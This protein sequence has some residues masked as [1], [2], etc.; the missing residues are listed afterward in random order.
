MTRVVKQANALRKLVGDDCPDAVFDAGLGC[1]RET[2]FFH[3]WWPDASIFGFEP[4]HNSR[5]RLEESIGE[6][7]EIFPNAI[8]NVSHETVKFHK[9]RGNRFASSIFSRGH[10]KDK[11]YEVETRTF[12]WLDNERGPF[13]KILLWL[14]CEGAEVLALEGAAGLLSRGAIKW[15]NVEMRKIEGDRPGVA[16]QSET[17]K[18]LIDAGFIHDRDLAVFSAGNGY[19]STYYHESVKPNV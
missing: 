12:D 13:N 8:S 3:E 15:I 4:H 6:F 7:V 19:D 18:L 10:R 5:E 11:T 16:V 14:D 1:G 17:H 2:I 9:R